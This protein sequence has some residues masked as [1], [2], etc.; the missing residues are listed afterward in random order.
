MKLTAAGQTVLSK[1]NIG[2]YYRFYIDD[3]VNNDV[4]SYSY[5]YNKDFSAAALEVTLENSDGRYSSGGASEVVVGAVGELKEGLL[6]NGAYETFSRFKGILRQRQISKN[7]G[8]NTIVFT[9]LD[10]IVKLQ[11]MDIGD[12]QA[13]QIFESTKT[14]I[15]QTLG[16]YPLTGTGWTDL[17]QV[18]SGTYTNIAPNP[19][20]MIKIIRAEGTTDTSID[21]YFT[22]Y[23]VR[24]DTGQVLLNVPINYKNY[25]VV[26]TYQYYATGTYVEDWIEDIIIEADTF[27]TSVFTAATNLRTTYQAEEGA[28]ATDTMTTNTSNIT[29][30]G[31]VYGAGQ[32]WYTDYDNV[33]TDLVAGD[34]T[35]NGGAIPGGQF[36]AFD[37]RF[38]RLFLT[39]SHTGDTVVCT[40]NYQFSTLQATGI[41]IPYIDLTSRSVANRF[42]AINKLR[43]QLAP[44]YIL[45]TRGGNKIWGRYLYE[46]TTEDYTLY[47][48]KSLNYAEDINNVYTR[49]KLYGESNNPTNLM[50]SKDTTFTKGFT[51]SVHADE[52]QLSYIGE[53]NAGWKT[54]AASTASGVMVIDTS[55]PIKVWFNDVMLGGIFNPALREDSVILEHNQNM[56]EY[57]QS[58]YKIWFKDTDLVFAPL[59]PIDFYDGNGTNMYHLSC[60]GLSKNDSGQYLYAGTSIPIKLDTHL[61]NWQLPESI[62]NDERFIYLGLNQSFCAM[63]CLMRTPG[64][65]YSLRFEYPTNT[66]HDMP[67]LHPPISSGWQPLGIYTMTTS[68]GHNELQG[69]HYLTTQVLDA[70][71][72][73]SPTPGIGIDGGDWSHTFGT[74]GNFFADWR[75]LN[76]WIPTTING[77]YMYWIRIR[78]TRGN[79]SAATILRLGAILSDWANPA[80]QLPFAK[81]FTYRSDTKTFTDYTTACGNGTA[82][83]PFLEVGSFHS[84]VSK[85][86]YHVAH[87][88]GHWQVPTSPGYEKKYFLIAS[89]LFSP[90]NVRAVGETS[91][92]ATFDYLTTTPDSLNFDKMRDGDPTTQWQL[93]LYSPLASSNTIFTVDFGATKDIDAIDITAGF[94]NPDNPTDTGFIGNGARRFDIKNWYSIQYSTNGTDFYYVSK[95]TYNFSLSGGESKSFETDVLGEGFQA[96]Y[97]RLILEQASMVD[98]LDGRW[99]VSIVDFSAWTNIMIKADSK[100]ATT[101][102]LATLESAIT[103]VADPAGLRTTIGERTFKINEINK[104]LND[105]K[106]AGDRA[107]YLLKEYAKNATRVN[108]DVAYSPHLE[109]GQ[110]VKVIDSIN[111]INQNYFIEG[112]SNNQGAI[113]LQLAYYQ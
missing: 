86:K 82:S 106:K 85:A 108:V 27:G 56:A 71:N 93:I 15:T 9:F 1:K 6:V 110:T 73:P 11:E 48:E 64:R 31:T 23:S 74:M 25:D 77:E 54:Y 75:S 41:E 65:D 39:T 94:F 57:G 44:N 29:Y 99:V 24:Y 90:D 80:H 20:P 67:S 88:S 113:Q 7:K 32:V 14:A 109:L 45:M 69:A 47:L 13:E 95:E 84:S 51:Y 68:G 43:D 81:V 55:K 16:Y 26:A 103:T 66:H 101:D 61:G 83:M 96:R 37:K 58:A 46:K 92:K 87:P 70:W 8:K 98:Y 100:L 52:V 4:M 111:G 5:S 35:I 60:D 42:D 40:N 72:T 78:A 112:I 89:E 3:V 34:F 17:A 49:V 63:Q 97:L 105:K 62:T 10:Y 102:S 18:F 50:T 91:I 2:T 12:T 28:S 21:P 36:V 38:G 53:Y 59:F 22:G 76:D 79:T 30:N 104:N 33:Q 107:Y 19:E